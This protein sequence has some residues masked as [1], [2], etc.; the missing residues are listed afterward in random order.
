ML[1]VKGQVLFEHLG[2]RQA[3]RAAFHAL[4]ALGAIPYGF[5]HLCR[6]PCCLSAGHPASDYR[7]VHRRCDHNSL[8]TWLAVLA[9][10]AK[11]LPQLGSVTF[12][13]SHVFREDRVFSLVDGYN[14]IDL[15]DGIEPRQRDD[16][17]ELAKELE[18]Q[19]CP[20]QYTPTERFH[21]ENAHFLLPGNRMEF[22]DGFGLY[23]V[24]GELDGAE[25][26]RLDQLY[27]H[28][29][30]VGSHT[31]VPD[32]AGLSCPE[33]CLQYPV[34]PCCHLVIGFKR[35]LMN[36]KK[37]NVISAQAPQAEIDICLGS[38]PI[39]LQR[40]SGKNQTA[41]HAVKSQPYFL[42]TVEI[43]IGRVE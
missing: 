31:D 14:L 35:Q 17:S 28:L 5:H 36:L 19:L 23:E 16:V 27:G 12:H 4:P 24:E 7:V 8:F 32:L 26:P 21:G 3:V 20:I 9:P 15:P 42:L 38:R 29:D 41:S 2:D 39:A 34:R 37:V 6:K 22:F 40:F 25:K 43:H 10:A 13:S 33:N 18:A 30:A 1:L 11:L